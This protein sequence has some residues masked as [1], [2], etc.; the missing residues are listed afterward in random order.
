MKLS[1]PLVL[2]AAAATPFVSSAASATLAP[3][4]MVD[5]LLLGTP[6]ITGVSTNMGIA[7]NTDIFDLINLSGLS[8]NYDSLS[9]DFDDFLNGTTSTANPSLV[10]W[11]S[12]APN[13]TGFISF[14]LDKSYL[15][16][17]IGLWLANANPLNIDRQLKDF[18]VY[19]DDDDNPV[20]GL[21]IKMGSFTAQQIATGSPFAGQA[22][23]IP[24]DDWTAVNTQFIQLQIESNFGANST[25]LG[26]VAFAT[27][28]V[29]E[30]M[31][32]LGASAA[33]GFGAF[34]KRRQG[35]STKA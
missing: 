12:T 17:G 24:S 21:G 23:G 27:D 19:A 15:I 9:T 20:N 26:E 16:T 31:T 10:G 28:A 25:S 33:A 8:A 22:W 6:N 5:G 7:V 11:R 35:K 32:L 29:P 1:L 30:P 14:T 18:S 13:S 4:I 2:L 34:F 3:G